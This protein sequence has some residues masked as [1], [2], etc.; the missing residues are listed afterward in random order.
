MDINSSSA[1]GTNYKTMHTATNV[2]P[3]S[4]KFSREPIFAVFAVDGRPTKIKS[5]KYKP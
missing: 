2:I 3:Y 1:Q 4:R 5:A